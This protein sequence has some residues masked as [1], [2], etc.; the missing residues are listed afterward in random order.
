ML[1]GGEIWRIVEPHHKIVC[2]NATKQIARI[3]RADAAAAKRLSHW[4][5]RSTTA[6]ARA[7]TGHASKRSKRSKRAAGEVRAFQ[8]LEQNATALIKKIDAKCSTASPTS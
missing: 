1:T 7:S 8:K 3:H 5:T 4:R 6:A 2:A